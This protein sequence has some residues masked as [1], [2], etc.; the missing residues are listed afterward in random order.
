MRTIGRIRTMRRMRRMT[1]GTMGR[2]RT[3]ITEEH[4]CRI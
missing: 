2:V 3:T 4:F 1:M